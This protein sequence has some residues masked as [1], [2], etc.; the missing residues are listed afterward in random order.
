MGRTFQPRTAGERQGFPVLWAH[1]HHSPLHYS[2]LLSLSPS[3][4]VPAIITGT[5]TITGIDIITGDIA[6]VGAGATCTVGRQ[7]FWNVFAPVHLLT[8]RPQMEATMYISGE[9]LLIMSIRDIA[10]VVRASREATEL[11]SIKSAEWP[12]AANRPHAHA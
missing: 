7:T 3:S 4:L 8:A 1:N 6:G 2:G 11:L 5:S 12:R 10:D 9:G